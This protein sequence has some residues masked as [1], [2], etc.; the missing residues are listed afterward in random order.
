MSVV[1]DTNVVEYYLLKTEPFTREC[2]LF[3]RSAR[4]VYAPMSWEI[5]LLNTVWLAIGAGVIDLSEGIERLRL[6]AQLG[7]YSVPLA[8]LWEGTLTRATAANHPAYDTVFIELAVRLRKQLVTFDQGLL[9]KFP[10]T[11]IRPK[12]LAGGS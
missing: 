7:I 2:A 11:A 9:R 10:G 8:G 1:V 5:E 4:D 12:E 3:W 6:A